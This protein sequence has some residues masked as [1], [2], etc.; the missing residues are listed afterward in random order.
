MDADEM[1]NR[2][3]EL[4]RMRDSIDIELADLDCRIKVVESGDGGSDFA[5]VV[6]R[7]R[8]KGILPSKR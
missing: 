7:L 8:D 1:K 5:G 3:A 2:R 6:Q 4:L